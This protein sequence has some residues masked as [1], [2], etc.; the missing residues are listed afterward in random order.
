MGGS[1]GR[2]LPTQNFDALRAAEGR[3]VGSFRPE[4][5]SRA[6]HGGSVGRVVP[7]RSFL[8]RAPRGGSVGRIRPTHNR[9]KWRPL[10]RSVGYANYTFYFAPPNLKPTISYIMQAVHLGIL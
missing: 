7:T 9:S 2:A 6:P 4:F 5:F 10:G 3:S 1:G 8:R